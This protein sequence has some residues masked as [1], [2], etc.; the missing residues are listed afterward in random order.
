MVFS[1]CS[2]FLVLSYY[3]FDGKFVSSSQESEVAP[4]VFVGD[5]SR[6]LRT[7]L[8]CTDQIPSFDEYLGFDSV[9]GF[10]I[11]GDFIPSG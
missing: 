2:A 10:S 4:E 3:K 9:P 8:S 11:P 6:I 7:A 5:F 1:K